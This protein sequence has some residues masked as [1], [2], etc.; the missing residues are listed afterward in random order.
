MSLSFTIYLISVLYSIS[1]LSVL[2]AFGLFVAFVILFFVY[3]GAI[4]DDVKAAYCSWLK[5]CV[6]ALITCISLALFIPSKNEMYAMWGVI[7]LEK[8]VKEN[9]SIQELPEKSIKAL[10]YWLDSVIEDQNKKE[11]IN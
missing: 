5:K 1:V 8:I 6:I 7:S 4:D 10:N 9:K 3:N 11:N 2:M